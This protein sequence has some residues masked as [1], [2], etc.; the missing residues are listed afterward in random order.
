MEAHALMVKKWKSYH[1]ADGECTYTDAWCRAVGLVELGHPSS[2]TISEIN[3]VS[4]QLNSENLLRL[5]AIT[6]SEFKD[7]VVRVGASEQLLPLFESLQKN[8]SIIFE[9]QRGR[10]SDRLII[11]N[12]V[13]PNIVT[14][15]A[16]VV[17]PGNTPNNQSKKWWQFW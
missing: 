17:L 1:G 11:I 4:G 7:C 9:R 13:T 6:M 15:L 10:F 3:V 8:G 5:L 12:I 14:P 16:P 2:F